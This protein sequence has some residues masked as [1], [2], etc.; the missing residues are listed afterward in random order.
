MNRGITAVGFKPP[1]QASALEQKQ[2]VSVHAHMN[3]SVRYFSVDAENI[4]K[5]S[6]DA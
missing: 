4:I 5:S 1:V 6:A 3:T 2:I